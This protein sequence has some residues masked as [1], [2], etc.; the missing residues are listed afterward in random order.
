MSGGEEGCV[1]S[2]PYAGN[3]VGGSDGVAD[4]VMLNPYDDG[5]STKVEEERGEGVTL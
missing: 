2:V 3:G 5:L 1:V 4:L